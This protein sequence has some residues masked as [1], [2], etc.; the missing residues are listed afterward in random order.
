[1][2]KY[3]FGFAIEFVYI[4][5]CWKLDIDVLVKDATRGL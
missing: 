3:V 1:M 4:W 5:R 2:K